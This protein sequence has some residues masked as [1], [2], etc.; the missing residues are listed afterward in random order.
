MYRWW[1][2]AFISYLLTHWQYLKSQPTKLDW[3]QAAHQAREQLFPHEVIQC[4]LHDV[5]QIRPL[6][7]QLGWSIEISRLPIAV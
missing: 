3:Q 2:L 6:L 7:A 5:D 1:I 4:F